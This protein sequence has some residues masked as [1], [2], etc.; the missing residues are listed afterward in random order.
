ML[1]VNVAECC[2]DGCD[3]SSFEDCALGSVPQEISNAIENI[4]DDLDQL[5]ENIADAFDQLS[6]FIEEVVGN[7]S[8]PEFC[9]EMDGAIDC[10]VVGFCDVFSG[11]STNFDLTSFEYEEACNNNTLFLCGPEGFEDMCAEECNLGSDGVLDA[12]FCS[13]CNIATCCK[14]KDDDAT[15]FE[16]CAWGSLKQDST[17]L[18]ELGGSVGTPASDSAPE[19][20]G[21]P[22][23]EFVDSLPQD[24]APAESSGS[25]AGTPIEDS[26][27]DSSGS[28]STPAEDP[29]SEPLDSDAATAES[30]VEVSRS[31]SPEDSMDSMDSGSYV[32]EISMFLT[33]ASIATL[34]LSLPGLL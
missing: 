34:F 20:L 8:I 29:T 27:S 16:D 18:S 21:T 15:S 14:N 7:T 1:S 26:P 10:P 2:R 30:S 3:A 28:L 4:A 9:P 6:K 11:E 5:S 24:V 17:P 32:P 31:S 25:P 22:I 12:A 13:L 23:V 19:P 33:L